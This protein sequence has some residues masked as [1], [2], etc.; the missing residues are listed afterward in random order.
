MKKF[1]IHTLAFLLPIVFLGVITEALL[2]RIPNDYQL[3]KRYLDHNSRFVQTLILGNSHSFYGISP[4]F[5]AKKGFNAASVSQSL[6]YDYYIL[7]KYENHWNHLSRIVIPIDYFTL[8][9]NLDKGNEVWRLKNYNLYFGMNVSN[10]ISTHTEL[11]ST[12]LKGNLQRLRSYYVSK[13]NLITTDEYGWGTAYNATKNLPITAKIA[14][15]RH[16]VKNYNLL[17][18]HIQTLTDIIKFAKERH[19]S[20][21]FFTSPA[22]KYYYKGVDKAQ[23]DKTISEIAKLES[24]FGVKY[25]DF[26]RDKSFLEA[27]FYDADHLNWAGAKKLSLKIDSL[28][29]KKI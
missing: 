10:D 2:R 4:K 14:L 5:F 23:M 11:L 7:K 20:V 28:V 29:N 26:F 19:I 25:V 21:I 13:K 8:F 18:E 17:P 24:K 3:K 9:K 15:S 6:N 1:I 22:C 16:T 12:R 27:D